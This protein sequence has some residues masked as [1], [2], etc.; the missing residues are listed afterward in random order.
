[1]GTITGWR[2]YLGVGIRND[3]KL[4]LSFL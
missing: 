1:M 4:S 2:V 3:E